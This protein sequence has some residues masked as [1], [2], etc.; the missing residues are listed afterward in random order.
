MNF[1]YR[2][3]KNS[4]SLRV[5]VTTDQQD[6]GELSYQ[7]QDADLHGTIRYVA[8][9]YVWGSLKQQGSV[10][11]EGTR[12]AVTQNLLRALT[13]LSHIMND[14]TSRN[15]PPR[16]IWADQLCINQD[17]L[18]ER[19]SQVALMGEVYT[20][21]DCVFVSLGDSLTAIDAAQAIAA[22]RPHIT[23]CLAI[24]STFDD[25]PDLSAEDIQG[26]SKL[27]WKAIQNMLS[28][29]WFRR[30]WVVQEVALAK[31][32]TV[33]YGDSQFEWDSLMEVFV[34]QPQ[35]FT[36]SMVS[37]GGRSTKFGL[38]STWITGVSSDNF[39]HS[40]PLI[41]W[42]IQPA[43]FPQQIH[44]IISPPSLATPP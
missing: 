19:S 5:L 27:D 37:A 17:D 34:I 22:L 31:K 9:S 35:G 36:I 4:R 11:I 7:F 14:K 24:H 32:A 21:A 28:A 15:L 29:P 2:A 44:A 20:K 41:F 30:A 38:H 13:Q 10:M 16:G 6:N 12:V 3:L 26:W 23:A 39:D 1:S 40:I 33:M 43:H 8:L 18:D 42:V 25:M